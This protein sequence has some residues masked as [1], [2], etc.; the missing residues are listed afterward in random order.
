MAMH[1]AE[2]ALLNYAHF[3]TIKI[4]CDSQAALLALNCPEAKAKTVLVT[5]MALDKLAISQRVTLSWI[6]AHVGTTGNELAD[7]LAKQGAAK[8]PTEPEPLIPVPMRQLKTY[9]QTETEKQWRQR[10][11]TS[12]EARQSKDFWPKP[13][14]ICSR[15]L[16]RYNRVDFSTIR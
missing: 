14:K 6:K 12:T 7:Q 1:D 4:F 11:I 8:I 15:N 9:I 2:E 5:M 3:G 13:N 16:L 10:W